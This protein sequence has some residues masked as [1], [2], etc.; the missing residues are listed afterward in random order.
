MID[1]KW[2]GHHIGEST[3]P[4]ERGRLKFFAKAIGETNPVYLDEAAA[5]AAGYADLPAPP[6]FLFAA[7]LDSGAMFGL[8]ETLDVPASKILHGEEQFEYLGPVVAGDTVV[9]SSQIKDIYDKKGGALE[10]IEIESRVT[11]QYG[12]PVANMRSVVVVRN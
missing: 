12:D 5:R 4:I 2:I 6:T 3:L 8:L 9:V 11:N 7:E 10:F 1:K